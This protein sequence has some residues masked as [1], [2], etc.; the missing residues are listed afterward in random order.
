M[1][2]SVRYGLLFFLA[3]FFVLM[4]G[5]TL[6]YIPVRTDAAFLLT[7]QEYIGITPWLVAFFIHVFTSMIPLAAGFTQF[8]PMHSLRR[9]KIHRIMGKCYIVVVLFISGPASFIMALLANGGLY[10]RIA[11]TTLSLLWMY[12]TAQA[13]RTV[14]A[15]Q[16]EQHRSWMYRSYA[17]TLSAITLRS[18]KW[19][20][21]ALFH[22]RPLD[23]YKII[24]W[25][26]FIPNLLLAEWLIALKNKKRPSEERTASLL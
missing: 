9:K 14:R 7:K 24:A 12:S 8:A 3:I 21:V 4:A 13:W 19:L 17:L 1:R 2:I 18:W 20:L 15:G 6:Q 22:L 16:Y 23:T 26:G 10:S 25:L 5:I 11:F